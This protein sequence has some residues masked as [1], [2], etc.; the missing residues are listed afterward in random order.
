[1]FVKTIII[2]A[3][4]LILFSLGTALLH[5]MK[6]KEQPEKLA[7]ALS[8]RIG[9]SVI[10]FIFLVIAILSGLLKPHGVSSNM[11]QTKKETMPRPK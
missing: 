3:F 4:I 10:L 7:K 8:Y 1:M 11:H 9:L 2:L 6:N 5:M